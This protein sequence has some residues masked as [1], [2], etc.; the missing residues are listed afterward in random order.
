MNE[1][2]VPQS[3]INNRTLSEFKFETVTVDKTGKTIENKTGRRQAIHG[4][5]RQWNYS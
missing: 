4:T 5:V 2:P 3:S 1:S